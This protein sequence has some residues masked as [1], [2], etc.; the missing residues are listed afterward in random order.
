MISAVL[1]VLGTSTLVFLDNDMWVCSANLETLG[2]DTIP[3]TRRSPPLAAHAQ[4][5]FFALSEWRKADKGLNCTLVNVPTASVGSKAGDVAF[6]HGRRLIVVKGGFKFAENV[7]AVS[8]EE[9]NTG[10][11]NG[12]EPHRGRINQ[13]GQSSWVMVSESIDG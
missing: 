11:D 10:H 13:G 1:G 2:D 9:M 6:A 12:V 3:E 5:H 7:I 4:R 8:R